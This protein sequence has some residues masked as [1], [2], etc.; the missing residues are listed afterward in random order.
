MHNMIVGKVVGG[1]VGAL[2]TI[3]YGLGLY[4]WRV[5]ELLERPKYSVV[6]KLPGGIEIRAYEAYVIAE[7]TMTGTPMSR[8]GGGAGRGACVVREGLATSSP[9]IMAVGGFF[10]DFEVIR[11]QF[12]V[13]RGAEGPRRRTAPRSGRRGRGPRRPTPSTRRRCFGCSGGL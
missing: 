10:L 13:S 4:A 9:G 6:E 8:A 7:A 1:I 11:T 2:V 12:A 3:R 5:S